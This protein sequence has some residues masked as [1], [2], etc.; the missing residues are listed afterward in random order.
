M[1]ILGELERGAL[2]RGREDCVE[3]V[4]ERGCH[5]RRCSGSSPARRSTTAAMVSGSPCSSRKMIGV[6][7]ALRAGGHWVRPPRP[8]QAMGS[9]RAGVDAG[10]RPGRWR[11]R[12]LVTVG[13]GLARRETRLVRGFGCDARCVGLDREPVKGAGEGSS[14]LLRTVR[15]R[16]RG[17]RR[18]VDAVDLG[19]PVAGRGVDRRRVVAVAGPR[20]TPPVR[21]PSRRG[22]RAVRCLA[23]GLGLCEL[24]VIRALR[25]AERV[26]RALR[27]LASPRRHVAALIGETRASAQGPAGASAGAR[28]AGPERRARRYS[29][30]GRRLLRPLSARRPWRRPPGRAARC[31]SVS[32]SHAAPR[33]AGRSRCPR[34]RGPSAHLSRRQGPSRPHPVEGQRPVPNGAGAVTGRTGVRSGVVPAGS[35]LRPRGHLVPAAPQ[36]PRPSWASVADRRGMASVVTVTRTSPVEPGRARRRLAS[37][38][39]AMRRPPGRPR[40]R[41]APDRSRCP[42]L[43]TCRHAAARALPVRG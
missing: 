31:R 10:H 41:Q 38:T 18:A 30:S 23:G 19:E 43:H 17:P 20:G 27:F 9:G 4:A 39:P 15:V 13:R 24:V 5:W 37:T 36:P 21:R 1:G 33:G 25:S 6:V 11:H 35:R 14:R 3:Q 28:A 12:C 34:R 8:R 42:P 2:D 40:G 7:P 29:R 16:G 22:S 26:G 32:P